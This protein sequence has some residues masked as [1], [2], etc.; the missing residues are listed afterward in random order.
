MAYNLHIERLGFREESEDG[1][2]T[3][4]EWIEYCNKKSDLS[5]E[6]KVVTT[7]PN[8]GEEISFPGLFCY[9][10]DLSGKLH[11]FSFSSGR[12][13]FGGEDIQIPKAKEIAHDLGAIVVGDEGEEY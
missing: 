10:A 13:T 12:V 11:I 3:E 8:T 5:F 4:S 9:W 6:T 2:I 1:L 7:N